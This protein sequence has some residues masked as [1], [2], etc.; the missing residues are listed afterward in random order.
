[1]LVVLGVVVRRRYAALPAAATGLLL[2]AM[3]PGFAQPAAPVTVI[4][5]G[6]ADGREEVLAARATL[7]R[8]TAIATP[9]LPPSVVTSAEYT[10]RIDE[11]AAHVIAKLTV[12]SFR[13]GEN[14]VL[15]P[16]SEARLEG[17][18]VDGKQAFPAATR[19]D[20]Y[21]SPLGGPGSHAI[22]LR[23]AATV[24]SNGPEREVRFGVPEVPATKLIARLPAGARL[25]AVVGRVGRMPPPVGGSLEADLGAVRL[26]HLRWREGAGGSAAVKVREGCIWDVTESAASLT[27]AY[28]VRV[29]Q[30]TISVLRFEVPAE[31]EVVRVAART[32]DPAAPIAL[33]DWTL[34]PEQNGFRLLRLEFQAP[35]AGRFVA[36]LACAPRKPLT[37]QPVLR[38]PRINL[39]ATT[40]ES[41][42]V[43]GFRAARV[44]VDGVGLINATDFPPD[45][46][47]D[48]NTVPDLK[49]DPNVPVRAFRPLSGAVAELRPRLRLGD[50][51]TVR[52]ATAWHIGP[53]RADGSGT[54]S[55]SAKDP[56]PLF[57]FTMT[58]ARV[59]EVRGPDVAAWN[60]TGDRVQVWLRAGARE[61]AVEWTA[62]AAQPPK[63]G[64]TTWFDPV[65]P[66][67]PGARTTSDEVQVHAAAGWMVRAERFR[68]WHS[69][70]DPSGVLRFQSEVQPASGLRVQLIAEPPLVK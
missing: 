54:I 53:A 48:F 62:A 69:T 28:L 27:A 10:V 5:A 24:T 7:D 15:L 13:S 9:A 70:P 38:F 46:L 36:V 4:L 33:R 2:L 43:Y 51:P 63:L 35:I 52:T 1:V 6:G 59:Y 8:L 47:K 64:D 37:R 29:D 58:G 30:G 32:T 34:A 65:H 18:I 26:V 44:S 60:H 42:A 25:P 14:V 68:G 12:H 22:E 31:L 11:S 55:W 23:F 3:G 45:A 20:S 39:S 21:A 57:E 49:L 67:V 17:V 61:G 16:L 40:V 41:E 19:P 66:K 56:L 50:S